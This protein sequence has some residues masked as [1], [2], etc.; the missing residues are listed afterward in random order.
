MP[1]TTVF[2]A[3]LLLPLSLMAQDSNDELE[4]VRAK[5][6]SM[7][8]VIEPENVKASPLDDWFVVQK[9][10]VIAYVSADGRYLLQ[11]DLIDLDANVNLT[12]AARNDSRRALVASVSDDEVIR[13]APENPQHTVWIFTDVDCGYCRRLHAQIEEYMANGI[14]VRY[15]LYPR[16]GPSSEAWKTSEEVWCSAD[17]GAALTNAKLDREFASIACDASIIENHYSLGRE[18]GLSGTPAIVLED[19][20]LLGGY[21][22]PQTLAQRLSQKAG[23]PQAAR[24]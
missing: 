18:V 13:F 16:N 10:S 8:D 24:N 21:L 1:K 9:G 7:F 17:R 11:G 22:P 12:E 5:I 3:A 2:L 15:F 4:S 23:T 14:E 19:G 6:A 20:E